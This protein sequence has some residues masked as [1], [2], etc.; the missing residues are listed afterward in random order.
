MKKRNLLLVVLTLG[1][2]ISYAFY[3]R[4]II[5][6]TGGKIAF[7]SER[8]GNREIYIMNADGSG[9]TRLTNNSADDVFASFNPDG[10]KIAFVSNR[11]GNREIY[12]M[13]ADGSGQ[14]RL[15]HSSTDESS[16][17]FSPDGSKIAFDGPDGVN[18]M[19]TDGSG[20]SLLTNNGGEPSFSG[21]G[22]KIVYVSGVQN[23]VQTEIY[24]MN[25]DGSGQTRLTNNPEYKLYPSFSPDS[26]KIAYVS[27]VNN[28][29]TEI[30]IMNADGSGQTN[31]T[32]TPIY[33]FDPVFSPDGSKI[34]FDSE[35][36]N[37]SYAIFTMN[38]D[39]TGRTRLTNNPGF[40]YGPT[41][42]RALSV[43]IISGNI[44]DNGSPLSG[45]SVTLSGSSSKTTTTDASGNY[46]FVAFNGNYTIT[47]SLLGYTFAPSSA[48]IN[49]LSADQAGVNFSVASR[50]VFAVT[51]ANDSGTGSLRQAI[52]DAN[53][54][55]DASRIVFNISGTAPYTINLQSGL[56]FFNTPINLD[57]STQPGFSAQPL[58]ELNGASAGNVDGIG[59][60]SDNS[61]IRGLVINRFSK[62]GI[63]IGGNNNTVAGNYI[64]TNLGGTSSLPVGFSSIYVSGNNTT[65]GGTTVADRNILSGSGFE[66]IVLRSSGNNVKGNY[67]GTNAAGTADISNSTGGIA[68]YAGGSNN[69]IG[70][71]EAGARNVISGNN[72]AGININTFLGAGAIGNVV[73]GNYIGTNASGTAS[74]SNTSGGIILNEVSGNTIGGSGTGAGNLVS[75]NTSTGIDLINSSNN[76]ISGNYIGT[77]VGGS[78][79]IPNTGMGINVTN[80]SSNNMIGGTASGAGNLLSGN[81]A[82]GIHFI[83]NA[84][85]NQILGNRVGTN[86]AG[87]AAIPNAAH[88]IGVNNSSGTIIGGSQTG[89]SNL[90]SGNNVNGIA[91]VNNSTNNQVFGNYVGT[92]A[93]GT[94]ALPNNGDGI[95]L[96]VG[97]SG[98]TIGG[99]GT[100]EGNLVSGNQ[101][102][103]V[104]LHNSTNNQVL[105]N[106]IGTNADGTA[107]IANK[108]DGVHFDNSSG[109]TMQGNL[110]SGNNQQGV[111]FYNTSTNNQITGN[112][113]GTNAAGNGA[114]ANNFNGIAL[115]NSPSNNIIKGNQ[116]S[117][118]G[119]SGILFT[120]SAN[121]N[122][123]IGNFIGT[124]ATGTVALGNTGNGVNIIDSSNNLI[125]GASPGEPNIISGN[126]DTVPA[127]GVG[128]GI[129]IGGST[130]TGNSIQGNYIGTDVTGTQRIANARGGVFIFNGA[131]N[132]A[133]GGAT[134]SPG[135]GAGNLISGNTFDGVS[136]QGASGT[137][138]GSFNNKVQ[139]NL[140]GSDVTGNFA[141]ANGTGGIRLTG[142]N[143]TVG[144]SNASNLI[145]FNTGSGINITCSGLVN[146]LPNCGTGNAVTSNT[147]KS[148]TTFGISITGKNSIISGNIISFNGVDGIFTT[149]TVFGNNIFS[150]NSG[151]SILSNTIQSNGGN[152]VSVNAATDTMVGGEAAASGNVIASNGGNGV[153]LSC[154][155]LFNNF[156]C[157]TGVSILS[158]SI[159]LNTA[160]G[161]SFGSFSG[162][163]ANNNQAAPVLSAASANGG[164]NAL[165]TGQ[166]TG[167]PNSNFNV[168]FFSNASCD[169][170]GAGE[171]QNYIGSSS[172]I[173]DSLGKAS[174]SFIGGAKLDEIITATATDSANN[175]S[176]FSQCRLVEQSQSPLC[177]T[178]S[179]N[180]GQ[181]ILGT[182]SAGACQSNNLFS[183]LNTF[184]G[185]AGDQIAITVD[186]AFYPT[187][188]LV[189]PQGNVVQS[190]NGGN[191]SRN[192]RL[193]ASEAF[194]SLPSSGTY[195]I[196]VSGNFLGE[197]GE[198]RLSLYK[199][200]S[201]QCVYTLSA[202][203]TNAT[204]T[205]GTFFF[206]VLTQ[207]GCPPINPSVLSG[208]FYTIASSSGGRVTFSVEPNTG[209][210]D[211]QAT[212]A[213]AGQTHTINQYGNVPPANDSFNDAVELLDNGS[214]ENTPIAGFNTNATAEASEPAHA[215]G[216]NPAKSV[217]YKWTAP[218]RAGLYSFTTSGSSFDT[219]MAIYACPEIGACSLANIT[220]VGSN[221]DTTRFDK[222]SKVNFRAAA[223][224]TYYIAVDGKNGDEGTIQLSFQQYERLYRLYLQTYNGAPSP[225]M[226]DSVTADN[227]SKVISATYISQGVY[228]FN[229]PAD[230]TLYRVNIS[231]PAGIVW[232]PNNI[233]LDDSFSILNKP[234]NDFDKPSDD[235]TGGGQNIVSN[236]TNATPRIITGFIKNITGQELLRLSVK[237]GFSQGPNPRDPVSCTTGDSPIGAMPYVIY[238]CQT[239]PNTLHD[240]IPNIFGKIFTLPVK[241]FS[242]PIVN[243]EFGLPSNALI[244][245]NSP[246]YNIS[247]RVFDGGAGTLVELS[248]TPR[249]SAQ[250]I[251]LRTTTDSDGFYEFKNLAPNI[252]TVKATRTGYTF[253]QL[254][255]VNL[256][257]DTTLNIGS[258]IICSYAPASVINTIAA[259]GGAS[260]FTITTNNPTCE[261]TAGTRESW[262][263][264]NSGATVGNGPVHFTVEAN[265]GAARTGTLFVA[266]QKITVNQSAAKSR[267][268]VGIVF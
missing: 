43:F 215:G 243:D 116:I 107:S 267:K 163:T 91:I 221:D 73:K 20:Q 184:S 31:L 178:G 245:S 210:T 12:I 45:V 213:V 103:G 68:I 166:V 185:N 19:N 10:N 159:Y 124:N 168:Q 156:V 105:G 171:G 55:P 193:P 78:A 47:P 76:Q 49:N 196:R 154:V 106:R 263:I 134:A 146:N 220:P 108:G 123:V 206:D 149:C 204:S 140:I 211:R 225:Q 40:D 214:S 170:S 169:A 84:G 137:V 181:S 121:N 165:I 179:I 268:R 48:S 128:H 32:N 27:Y 66:A 203:Q 144:G 11:D 152:G 28:V 208:N 3:A 58:V 207:N 113:I 182:L 145:A 219:V 126:K 92:N 148:N 195:T 147:I 52:I 234:I 72:G 61:I 187:L 131:N 94:S 56:P 17:T 139:G 264:I 201:A 183:D 33:E 13:N 254:A 202:A 226:P 117:G 240:I 95:I 98:N 59:I 253:N 6:A 216:G 172:V 30:F 77:N 230:K 265:N 191:L 70:G 63:F 160:L 198:Y 115:A 250:V 248:Y 90:V 189:N 228:E 176:R 151:T 249:G 150:C 79:A 200:P 25:I 188:E 173:T 75:G 209:A 16:P 232:D 122:Q 97:P 231:G 81:G 261:W 37:N 180:Y 5:G 255:S 14:T 135:T 104:A 246:T 53:A 205:G 223:G 227:G 1:L 127:S 153:A 64:G 35:V 222:T 7:V 256:Q 167:A 23:N 130:A 26:S 192:L 4:Q 8:D 199:A 89:A 114:V 82:T 71:S 102:A 109:N 62:Q 236:A 100:G 194:Y 44:N 96:T 242:F 67:I 83:N 260:Q 174:F 247:G 177:L 21:D 18:I 238:Q 235:S 69:V 101:L 266:G 74:V 118:N 9:Q 133:V 252:Y 157:S 129:V 258:Q 161:I 34:A 142:N 111:I 15:T 262:I 244:A 110:I 87:D 218:G 237:I 112:H 41:W 197:S 257:A 141:L 29:Q 241:S 50:S 51:N 224:A 57:A 186:A 86:A 239:Q 251:S 88:G 93:S 136:I 2:S 190:V 42:S 65:I 119:Q 233:P 54:N 46:S 229:L 158:N 39:G 175:T 138:A 38:T 80:N 99:S 217:W 22:R 212:I 155:S 143:N 85:V 162:Q 36:E 24:V 259:A 164:D 60:N 120:N 125:G 132:N